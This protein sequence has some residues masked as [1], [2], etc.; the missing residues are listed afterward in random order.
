[1]IT[2]YTSIA[3]RILAINATIVCI[4]IGLI[5]TVNYKLYTS[6]NITVTVKAISVAI[7]DSP[8]SSP[9]MV[10]SIIIR[11]IVITC[12]FCGFMP[13]TFKNFTVI[14]HLIDNHASQ[15]IGA[16]LSSHSFG[17]EVVPF[18]LDLLP[19]ALKDANCGITVYTRSAVIEYTRELRLTIIDTII[20]E[21]IV[22]SIDHVYASQLFAVLIVSKATILDCPAF[23]NFLNKRIAI[24]EGLIGATK[25]C[26]GFAGQVGVNER[27]QSVNLL[28]FGLAS[29]G[30]EC[31]SSKVC[32]VA[33]STGVDHVQTI[34]CT[35]ISARLRCQLNACYHAEGVSSCGID[36][37]SLVNP[38]QLEGYS[39]RSFIKNDIRQREVLIQNLE[40]ADIHLKIVVE[41]HNCR[42]LCE[43]AYALCQLQEEIPRSCIL[44]VCTG[45]HVNEVCKLRR[46]G[47][48][49]HINCKDIRCGHVFVDI[50]YRIRNI[51]KCCGIGNITQPCKLTIAARSH[52]EVEGI[53]T[54]LE[55]VKRD[56]ATYR[57]IVCEICCNLNNLNAGQFVSNEYIAVKCTNLA[58][59]YRECDIAHIESN[60]LVVVAGSDGE[61]RVRAINCIHVRSGEVYIFGNNN[62]HSCHT[63]NLTV[64]HHVNLNCAVPLAGEYAISG[65]GGETIVG[66]SPSIALRKLGFI[67]CGADALCVHLNG[68]TDGRISIV[69]G[70]VS[71]IKFRG[72]GG[73]RNDHPGS[74]YRALESVGGA[75]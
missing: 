18:T 58:V 60:R 52:A 44:E 65:D 33:E 26:A 20:T 49:S 67:T 15:C 61:N 54:L 55:H 35:P 40:F 50:N 11:S 5:V 51:I 22:V 38:V 19:P 59:F 75:V 42:D 68:C 30:V 71:M 57:C 64:E 32:V 3:G 43:Y 27:C 31:I 6:Q 62:I 16:S 8:N 23:L 34:I 1:M 13:N 46:N 12:S 69:A 17:V 4:C 74:R 53:F 37:L 39:V 25:A 48:L 7:D 41:V 70:N 56:G 73:G 21:V 10:R 24:L 14:C 28:I 72:A 29:E 47:D 45:K 9:R 66:N 36:C 63:D 2:N